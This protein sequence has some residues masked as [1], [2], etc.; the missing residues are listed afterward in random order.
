MKSIFEPTA[1]AELT[2]RLQG[3]QADTAA[4]WGKMNAAQMCLHCY[5]TFEVANGS[6]KE[7]RLFIGRILGPLFK[8]SFYN[9]KAWPKS[10]KTS[11]NYII[12]HQP[13][14]EEEKSSLLQIMRNFSLAGEAGCTTHPNPFFGEITPEQ[15]G[16]GMYKHLDH[17]LKQ[18]GL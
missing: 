7:N 15:Y 10:T 8:A 4:L 3:L 5:K 9:D 16:K 14:F 11:P 18:F 1:L 12:T 13:N 6:I 17:H 2:E